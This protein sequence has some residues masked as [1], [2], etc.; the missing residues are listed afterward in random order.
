[1][2]NEQIEALISAALAD[3]ML[4][5]KEKQVLFK[6]AQAQGIDLDEFEMVLDARLVELEKAEKA[7]AAASAPKS[8][9][10]GDVKKCPNC[11]A[12]VQSYQGVCA[13]CG[14]AFENIEV[15]YASKELSNLLMKAKSEKDMA[16]I[17]DTFPIPMEKAALIA[18][19]TWLA[20]QSLD[21]QN[22][23]SKSY[24]KKYDE[25]I[26]KAKVTFANDKDIL[27]LITQHEKNKILLVK[28][29]LVGFI[30]TIVKNKILWY[31]VGGILA[32]GL[33]VFAACFDDIRENRAS[34]KMLAAIDK[35]EL[36]KAKEIYKKYASRND[37]TVALI[38]EYKGYNAVMLKAHT[39][40]EW[41]FIC[42]EFDIDPEKKKDIDDDSTKENKNL[43]SIT[44]RFNS[45]KSS[46]SIVVDQNIPWFREAFERYL[47]IYLGVADIREAKRE[48]LMNYTHKDGAPNNWKLN[49]N[50][51]GIYNLLEETGTIKAKT[52]KTVSRKQA[53]F[54][55]DYLLAIGLINSDSLIDANNIR[56]RLNSLMKN[57]DSIEELTEELRYKSSPNN[58]DGTRLF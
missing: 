44:I 21:V 3:G 47:H 17:I 15:N 35:D 38:G 25:V 8:N 14:Y 43:E 27:P 34:T 10:V 52:K 48:Y 12:I 54:I 30:K 11:G 46:K 22:P 31:I 19:A 49:R 2:Y 45:S 16:T 58:V 1:M 6:K 40:E 53:K 36:N 24:Q 28:N 56:S 41:E 57:Y 9:K 20:P 33:I 42:K 29:Q 18:F 51:W 32:I 5:E 26:N 39:D 4:T 23:L 13:E 7:K 37:L 55:E 50:I